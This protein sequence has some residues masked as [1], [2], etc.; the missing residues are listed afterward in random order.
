GRREHLVQTS[1]RLARQLVAIPRV[2]STNE[3]VV[4]A[5]NQLFAALDFR[6]GIDRFV[7][8]RRVEPAAKLV[9]QSLDLIQRLL[10]IGQLLIEKLL[11]AI[12]LNRLGRRWSRLRNSLNCRRRGRYGPCLRD[13][14]Q[15]AI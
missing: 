14:Q 4:V 3:R 9:E 6:F 13:R 11:A 5:P 15:L 12:G 7:K 10:S 2:A 1:N 8:F